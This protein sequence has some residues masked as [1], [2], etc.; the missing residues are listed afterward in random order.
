MKKIQLEQLTGDGEVRNLSGHQRGLSA[1]AKFGLDEIDRSSETAVVI[2]PET[3]YL[4]SS[5]FFQGMFAASVKR[6]GTRDSFL[7]KY[8]FEAPDDVLQQVDRGIRASLMRR[9]DVIAA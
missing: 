4:L 2:V 3:I 9:E 1:R 5:S 6:A 7:A 8:Q